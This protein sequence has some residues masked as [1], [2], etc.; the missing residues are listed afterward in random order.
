MGAGQAWRKRGE[1]VGSVIRVYITVHR[2][3]DASAAAEANGG[4]VVT[5]ASETPGMGR[6]AA[7]R[8]SEG[9]E[10]GLWENLPA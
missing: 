8:D 2:L 3:E 5:P 10:I 7:L 4:A 9:N 1:S 6:C